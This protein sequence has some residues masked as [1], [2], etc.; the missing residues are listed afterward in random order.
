VKCCDLESF[1]SHL[2]ELYKFTFKTR[3]SSHCGCFVIW[4]LTTECQRRYGY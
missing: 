3:N 2:L 1:K 4:S